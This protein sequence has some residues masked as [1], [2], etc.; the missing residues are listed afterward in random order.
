MTYFIDKLEEIS[1]KFLHKTESDFKKLVSQFWSRL[2][3]NIIEIKCFPLE[4]KDFCPFSL[5]FT[6]NLSVTYFF[7]IMIVSL[8]KKEPLESI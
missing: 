5:I 3:S 1:L 2:F 7:Q 6:Q 8:E 4:R